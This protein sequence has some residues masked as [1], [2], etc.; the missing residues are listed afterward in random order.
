MSPSKTTLSALP[1]A[2]SSAERGSAWRSRSTRVR[3]PRCRSETTSVLRA[4]VRPEPLSGRR[5]GLAD[6][7][8][9]HEAHVLLDHLELAHVCH[10]P[11]SEVVDQPLHE[12]L[13]CA[14][15][16]GDADHAL[17]NNPFLADLELVV[18]QV[19][20]STVLA[21]HLDQ[22]V[23]VRRVARANYQD[24]FAL[25]RELLDGRLAV[26]SGVADVIGA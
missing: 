9:Q 1:T 25:P 14:G 23:G 19:G 8:G 6:R 3:A 4:S 21:R 26:G 18:D 20:V 15:A 17:A 24:H 22:A 10:A 7:L 16:G 13:R 11:A 2:P 5:R 12:L